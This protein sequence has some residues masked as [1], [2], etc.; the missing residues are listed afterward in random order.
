MLYGTTRNNSCLLFAIDWTSGAKHRKL[1]IG[2]PRE[3]I[4][5]EAPLTAK[6]A[7]AGQQQRILTLPSNKQMKRPTPKSV[8]A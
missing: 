4:T 6:T 1:F 8:H 7:T 2:R 3:R 5:G